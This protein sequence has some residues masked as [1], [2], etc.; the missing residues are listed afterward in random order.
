MKRIFCGLLAVLTL[1]LAMAAPAFAVEQA[2]IEE[3][4]EERREDFV[5]RLLRH[6]DE[7]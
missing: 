5:E 2:R 7:K 6:D 1:L 4:A 3:H